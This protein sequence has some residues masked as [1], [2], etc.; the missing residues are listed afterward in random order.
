MRIKSDDP[1]LPNLLLYP[2]FEVVD[3][4]WVGNVLADQG[5]S[6]WVELQH[7]LFAYCVACPCG[8]HFK[9]LCPRGCYRWS[10][11]AGK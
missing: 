7:L 3:G 1:R 4:V 10:L 6:S 5:T 11:Q 2:D 8:R 9:H